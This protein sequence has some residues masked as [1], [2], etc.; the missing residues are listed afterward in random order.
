MGELYQGGIQLMG[1]LYSSY[2]Q[3]THDTC[4]G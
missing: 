3:L 1:E 2:T 4:H